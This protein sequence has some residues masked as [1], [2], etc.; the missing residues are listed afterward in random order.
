MLAAYENIRATQKDITWFNII[1]NNI[2]FA[3]I[4]Q[5][6]ELKT[7]Y[8]FGKMNQYKLENFKNNSTDYRSLENHQ[9]A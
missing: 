7:T 1:V 4:F 2:A 8:K 9:N 5:Y 3:K 6:F